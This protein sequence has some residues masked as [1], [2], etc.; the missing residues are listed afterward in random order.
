M[1]QQPEWT[2]PEYWKK[3]TEAAAAAGIAASQL[4]KLIPKMQKKAAKKELD[5]LERDVQKLIDDILVPA[6]KNM[7]VIGEGVKCLIERVTRLEKNMKRIYE[8][9]LTY[10]QAVNRPLLKAINDGR[11]FDNRIGALESKPTSLRRRQSRRVTKK[12]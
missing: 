6:F 8:L 10:A 12:A 1:A 11:E 2:D 5:E 4:K 7:G 9:S 3:W